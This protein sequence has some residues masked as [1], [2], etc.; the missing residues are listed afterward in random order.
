MRN[1]SVTDAVLEE[2][3]RNGSYSVKMQAEAMLRE[4]N[5]AHSEQINKTLDERIDEIRDK[6]ADNTGWVEHESKMANHMEY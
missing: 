5:A 3:A 2:I 6:L 1:P 4:R